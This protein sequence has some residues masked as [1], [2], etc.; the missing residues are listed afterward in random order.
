VSGN[1]LSCSAKAGFARCWN[2]QHP[3]AAITALGVKRCAQ[4]EGEYI[5]GVCTPIYTD[6]MGTP[7]HEDAGDEVT[8]PQAVLDREVRDSSVS[9][10]FAF[11][12]NCRTN[13]ELWSCSTH[14]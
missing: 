1:F 6:G 3:T 9:S 5:N 14:R 13:D 4:S 11:V 2:F 12:W 10:V 7:G 8:L